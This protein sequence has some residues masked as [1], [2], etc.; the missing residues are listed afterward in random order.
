MEKMYERVEDLSIHKE[1]LQHKVDRAE[2]ALSDRWV[3][4]KSSD[5]RGT[6]VRDAVNDVLVK[7]KPYRVAHDPLNGKVNGGAVEMVTSLYAYTRPTF[8]KRLMAQGA[9]ALLARLFGH[10][11]KP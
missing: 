11:R 5:I 3:M 7:W 8:F 4:I 6:L 9:G 1:A 2:V 10:S